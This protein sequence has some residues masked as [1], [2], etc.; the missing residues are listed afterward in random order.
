ML[1]LLLLSLPFSS[2]SI[3]Y[4]LLQEIDENAQVYVSNSHY[5]DEK[6][7]HCDFLIDDRLEGHVAYN[8]NWDHDKSQKSRFLIAMTMYYHLLYRRIKRT[9][10][11]TFLE[12]ENQESQIIQ[13]RQIIIQI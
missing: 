10:R 13:S 3:N 6:T 7:L 11:K 8:N 2:A 5:I 1:L 12:V 4:A 9:Y